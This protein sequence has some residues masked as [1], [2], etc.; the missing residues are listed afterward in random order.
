MAG[1][2][3]VLRDLLLIYWKR[4]QA[5]IAEFL[6]TG[7]K[8]NRGKRLLVWGWRRNDE[9]ETIYREIVFLRNGLDEKTIYPM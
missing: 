6:S 9:Q 4:S 3:S 1:M 5:E 7:P 8:Q 2:T